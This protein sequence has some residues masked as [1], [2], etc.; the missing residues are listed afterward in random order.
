M[1]VIEVNQY[2]HK[3]EKHSQTTVLLLR[4]RVQTHLVSCDQ[5]DW[6]YE[7]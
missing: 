5:S 2:F 7:S 6:S 4:V 1:Q 3:N